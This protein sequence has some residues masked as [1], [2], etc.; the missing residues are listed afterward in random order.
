MS[1]KH[2][3]YSKEEID[4]YNVPIEHFF[5]FAF[6]IDC[7]VF[8]FDG[9]DLKVLLIERGAE[10]MKGH[11]A[12]PGDLVRPE[13][14]IDESANDIL[15][16]LTGVKDIFLK[17]V[18]TFGKVDRHPLG[19]VVTIGYY[20][21]VDIS[22]VDIEAASWAKT[23][24]WWNLSDLPELGF[25]HSDII[26]ECKEHLVRDAKLHPIGFELLPR[27]FT[28]AQFQELYEAIYQTKLDKSNFRKKLK[29]LN[30][31][32]QLEEYQKDVSHRP[33]KL[34][35]FDRDRYDQLVNNGFLF[36]V[37]V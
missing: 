37:G 13:K 15:E 25:D 4:I 20:A 27:K 24:K 28:L 12:L 17:Q 19:R 36:D 16:R 9:E 32:N 34:Y 23:V 29:S 31:L 8:G 18:H 30:I 26:E 21:L 5:H 1:K 7:V 22:K 33:A 11:W 2:P 14:G 6:S 3:V 35:E 10:P